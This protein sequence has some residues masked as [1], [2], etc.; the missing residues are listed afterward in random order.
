MSD[1]ILNIAIMGAG[2]RMGQMLVREVTAT[3]GCH[4]IGATDREGSPHIGEDAGSLA[5]IKALGVVIE[6][7]PA[8]VIAR[9]HAVI[10]FTTPAATVEHTRDRKSVV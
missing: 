10:D 6:D 4:V 9:A 3:E 7:D 2:G 5:G 1:G 8:P